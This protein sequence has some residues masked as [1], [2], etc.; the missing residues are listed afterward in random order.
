MK[1]LQSIS[2]ANLSLSFFNIN[3]E[4]KERAISQHVIKTQDEVICQGE[5][6]PLFHPLFAIWATTDSSVAPAKCNVKWSECLGVINVCA[7]AWSSQ[8]LP[9]SVMYGSGS[10][11][12]RDMGS[13]MPNCLR[14]AM[15]R[16]T[17]TAMANSSIPWILM[18]WRIL[19]ALQKGLWLKGKELS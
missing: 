8:R 7:S 17:T 14:T 4:K 10:L 11:P 1:L 6:Q 18:T 2:N 13:R 19:G 12:S 16:I 9:S 15:K 5:P 3:K